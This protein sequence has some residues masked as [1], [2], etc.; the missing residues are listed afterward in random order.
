MR[1]STWL[2]LAAAVA[3]TISDENSGAVDFIPPH[4][5]SGSAAHEADR[6]GDGVALDKATSNEAVEYPNGDVYTGE[7]RDGKRNGIGVYTRGS[8]RRRAGSGL[9]FEGVWVEDDRL[10]S[11]KV[12]LTDGQ[13]VLVEYSGRNWNGNGSAVWPNGSSYTGSF[14]D[15]E[16]SGR[17]T[18]RYKDG[19]VYVGEFLDGLPHGRGRESTRFGSVY[20]GSYEY[21]KLQGSGRVEWTGGAYYTGGFKEGLYHGEGRLVSPDGFEYEGTFVA[22]RLTGRGRQIS[23]A[24]DVYEGDFEDFRP[25]GEGV[26]QF[27]DGTV[28][29]GSFKNGLYHG[30]GELRLADGY[31]YSGDFAE[32]LPHGLGREVSP[33]GETFEGFFDKGEPT[34]GVFTNEEGEAVLGHFVEGEF[35]PLS[36]LEEVSVNGDAVWNDLSPYN[37]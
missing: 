35:Y 11:V 9:R 2:L 26:V 21:G 24:G 25:H 12:T 17:G 1:V 6:A 29:A 18:L 37:S 27:T 33:N 22:D 28:Y 31:L 15:G 23:P 8:T 10:G 3:M 19:N 16:Y 20:E 13:E 34:R 30:K 36:E 32:D 7:L 4:L 14:V 5:V